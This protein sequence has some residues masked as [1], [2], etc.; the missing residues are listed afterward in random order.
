MKLWETPEGWHICRFLRVFV[1]LF[2][3]RRRGWKDQW[4][5]SIPVVESQSKLARSAAAP[6]KNKTIWVV[7]HTTNMSSLRGFGTLSGDF[8]ATLDSV[9]FVQQT[10]LKMWVMTNVSTP[11]YSQRFLRSRAASFDFMVPTHKFPSPFLSGA[12]VSAPR[13]GRNSATTMLPTINAS[14]TIIMG[15]ISEVIDVTALSTWSS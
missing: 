8:E 9:R 11:S 5:A 2:V 7:P 3:F 14:T 4:R 10:A 12:P 6:P 13:M 1:L 15:S